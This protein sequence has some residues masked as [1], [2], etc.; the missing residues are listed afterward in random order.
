MF[1]TSLS[2]SLAPS[3]L[4]HGDHWGQLFATASRAVLEVYAT[5]R[6][7]RWP[8]SAAACQT[9]RPFENAGRL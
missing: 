4:L 2:L 9:A 6:A 8:R 7:R 1:F 5:V 3:Y